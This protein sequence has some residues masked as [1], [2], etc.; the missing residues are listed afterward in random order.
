VT[1]PN[2]GAVVIGRN[3]GSRLETCVRSVVHLVATVVYV[4]SASTDRSAAVA[5]ELGAE[6]VELDSAM[7]FTAARARNA[8][9]DRLSQ[10]NPNLEFVQFI[11][12]D[13]ELQPGW[14]DVAVQFL[15]NH[16]E[17]AIVCGRRRERYPLQTLYNRLCDMEW[18]TPI[19]PT[20]ACGGDSLVRVSALKAAGGFDS[21]LIAGE[22]PDLCF[23]M[24]MSGWNIERLDSEM[25]L[26]DA[27][28]TRLSQWWQRNVR[29]GYATAEAYHR[30]GRQDPELSRKVL[31]NIFWVLP[32]A[33]PLWPLLWLRVCRKTGSLYASH[34]VSGKLPHLVGQVKFWRNQRRGRAGELIEYK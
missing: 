14:I 31:S 13:C 32:L 6:V 1:R 23:R 18:N 2:V 11:D 26:H 20:A 3:E 9:F 29:S 5:S 28:M 25:T 22:E 7:P 27:D 19:G 12:G 15:E 30:R 24:R 16:D 10:L 34:I 8:G 17:T 21:S 33:W 4:D